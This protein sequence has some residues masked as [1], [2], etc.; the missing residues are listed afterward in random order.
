MLGAVLRAWRRGGLVRTL[1]MLTICGLLLAGV[2]M[3][4][5]GL[6]LPISMLFIGEAE[7]SLQRTAHT[8]P[9][10]LI[11]WRLINTLIASATLLTIHGEGWVATSAL[12]LFIV[13]CS[14]VVGGAGL[15]RMTVVA[16]V[17]NIGL[18]VLVAWLLGRLDFVVTDTRDILVLSLPRFP[19]QS[20]CRDHAASTAA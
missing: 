17:A 10:H 4:L 8:D 6:L 7:L 20:V 19:G 18:P 9:W 1:A 11:A 12:G 2:P 13:S 16:A 5:N 15:A 3:P 14:G